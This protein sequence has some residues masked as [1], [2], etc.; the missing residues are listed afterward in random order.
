MAK[1][2]IV[3]KA[4]VRELGGQ[5]AR[6]QKLVREASKAFDDNGK[7][8]TKSLLTSIGDIPQIAKD[9]LEVSG[10]ILVEMKDAATANPVKGF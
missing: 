1:N 8:D 7:C 3:A 9:I 10:T 6:L 2:T 4:L 5:T